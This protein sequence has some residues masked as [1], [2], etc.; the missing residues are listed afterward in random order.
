MQLPSISLL[1]RS[2]RNTVLRSATRQL[3][4]LGAGVLLS[5]AVL[6]QAVQVE[7]AWVRATVPGQ[8]ATGAFMRLT[9]ASATRLVAVSTPAA[10]FAE[11]HEMRMDNNVMKMTPLKDG[12]ELPAGKAVDLQPGGFHVMLMDLPKPLPAGSTIPVTL[13]FRDAKGVEQRSELT[14]PVSS[15]APMASM[16]P[17][18]PMSP[19]APMEHSH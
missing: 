10:G 8:H 7:N 17:M 16:A 13:V 6:A 18:A 9:S 2:S 12:L 19:M 5:Q 1:F 4:T 14:L 15:K 3:L 11:V